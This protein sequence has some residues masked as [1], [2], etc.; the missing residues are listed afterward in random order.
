MWKSLKLSRVFFSL[1]TLIG[2][3]KINMT[4]LYLNL[5]HRHKK[6]AVKRLSLWV[7]TVHLHRRCRL[8]IL[9]QLILLPW[10]IYNTIL[11]IELVCPRKRLLR[12]DTQQWLKVDLKSSRTLDLFKTHLSING[13][14]LLC[15][16]EKKYRSSP[17]Q[18]PEKTI[19]TIN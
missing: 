4:L 11:Y 6:Q 17:S 15:K 12:Y 18:I 5:N 1:R 7:N 10:I 2:I 19:M 9:T 3:Y 16:P 14:L 13:D 8:R